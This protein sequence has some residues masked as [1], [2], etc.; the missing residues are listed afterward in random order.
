MDAEKPKFRMRNGSRNLLVLGL[1][2]IL[3]ALATTGAS[4]AIYHASGDIYLD[5]SRPGFL[6]D[7]TEVEDD[8][9]DKVEEEYDF[10][11]E[12][13]LTM[14]GLMKYLDMLGTEVEK[15]DEY[16]KPFDEKALSDEKLGIPKEEG[17][18][19]D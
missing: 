15:V 11:K 5:R 16:K 19:E 17:K 14:E 7:E 1:V 2:S 4:L 9:N 18:E 3:V 12:G 8:N 6:P 10:G 13:E